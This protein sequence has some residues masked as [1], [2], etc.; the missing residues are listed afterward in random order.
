MIYTDYVSQAKLCDMVCRLNDMGFT[1]IKSKFHK[2]TDE[3]IYELFYRERS[4][5]VI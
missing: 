1:V 3:K 4:P 2:T 5:L